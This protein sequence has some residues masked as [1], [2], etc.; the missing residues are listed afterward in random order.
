MVRAAVALLQPRASGRQPL[1][2]YAS[3]P[4]FQQT[5]AIDGDIGEGT[6]G[7]TEALRR[8][9][10]LPIGGP[11]G[12]TR[13]RDRPRAGPR[14][15]VRHHRQRS[16]GNLGGDAGA[17]A[18]RCGSSREWPSTVAGSGPRPHGHVDAG[19]DP[20]HRQG[21]LPDIQATRRS[22][23]L[24]LP[25]WSRPAGLRGWTLGRP[26]DRPAA[27]PAAGGGTWSRRFGKCSAS[28]PTNWW[29]AGM[30]SSMRRTT[31]CSARPARRR[32]FGP[33][34]REGATIEPATMCRRRS[35][36]MAPR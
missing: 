28:V 20:G 7:V 18:S 5:N 26:G 3:H 4:D 22:S 27:A 14:L 34:H 36:P 13:P 24:P 10:V 31:R 30:Q 17:T 8:R 12:D 25:L 19:R 35:A 23:L 21:L 6:G 16:P 9:I 2:L 29:R 15:P 32:R 11:L 33:R 1:I